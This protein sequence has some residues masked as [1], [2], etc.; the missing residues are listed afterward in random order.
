[1]KPGVNPTGVVNKY[2][3]GIFMKTF[4]IIISLPN[5]TDKK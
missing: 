3:I 5:G 4:K 2:F 1:M